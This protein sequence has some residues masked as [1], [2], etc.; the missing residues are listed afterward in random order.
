LRVTIT[1]PDRFRFEPHDDH[2][3]HNKAGHARE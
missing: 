3:R 1:A 2:C